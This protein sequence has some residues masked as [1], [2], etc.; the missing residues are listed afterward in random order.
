MAFSINPSEEMEQWS[1]VFK[2]EVE[3]IGLMVEFK[4]LSIFH[5]F[6]FDDVYP[7]KMDKKK[8]QSE[9]E[10]ESNLRN[11]NLIY[12]NIFPNHIQLSEENKSSS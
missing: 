11:Y 4:T 3:M 7:W 8:K 2:N 5:H 10:N 9:K 1:F 12:T 6:D